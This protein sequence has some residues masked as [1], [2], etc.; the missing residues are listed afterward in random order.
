MDKITT[1][2]NET[3]DLLVLATI[4]VKPPVYTFDTRENER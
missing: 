3:L 4:A 2:T 1:A